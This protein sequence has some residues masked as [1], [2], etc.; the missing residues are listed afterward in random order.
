MNYMNIINND[1]ST[2]LKLTKECETNTINQTIS[3]LTRKVN[4]L[5][6]E[7]NSKIDILE[8]KFNYMNDKFMSDLEDNKI[9]KND[10]T[11]GGNIINNIIDNSNNKCSYINVNAPPSS[12]LKNDYVT[13]QDLNII[14]TDICKIKSYTLDIYNE[15]IKMRNIIDTSE[16]YNAIKNDI[17]NL[18]SEILN[19]NNNEPYYLYNCDEWIHTNSILEYLNI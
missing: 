8:K 2:K 9:K 6:T 15:V 10:D 17:C 19:N 14:K 13:E 7:L 12:A 3:L 4:E 16:A 18:K 1:K 5:N 11:I